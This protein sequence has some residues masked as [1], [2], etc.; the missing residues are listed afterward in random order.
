MRP[1][2]KILLE[3]ITDYFNY[4]GISPKMIDDIKEKYVM[5]CQ[6][7]KQKMKII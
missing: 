5:T 1:N 3:N 4:K 7:Q 6:N 2:D